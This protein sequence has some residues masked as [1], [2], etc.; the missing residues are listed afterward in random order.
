MM[1]RQFTKEELPEVDRKTEFYPLSYPQKS[2]W[3]MEKMYPSTSFGNISATLKFETNLD[4]D[5]ANN[6]FNHVLSMND[7]LRLR[8]TEIEGEAHQYISRHEYKKFDYFDFTDKG[9]SELYKWDTEMNRTPIYDLDAP[10]FYFAVI[11]ISDNMAGFFAKLHHLI[12]DAWT[13]VTL[14]NELISCYFDIINGKMPSME[15][16]PSYIEYLE[17]EKTYFESER[18]LKDEGFWLEKFQKIPELTTL[19][20]RKLIG[21]SLDS[22]RKTFVLPEKLSKKIRL[23]CTEHKTSIFSLYMGAMA[24]YINRTRGTS[25]IVFGTPVLNRTNFREKET[26]GMFISTVPLLVNVDE[27]QNYT[28][29]TK[30][31]N[32]E[33]MSILRHQKYPYMLLLKKLRKKMPGLE[34]LY[35]IIISYQNAKFIK[36]GSEHY[37]EGRW[38]QNSSQTETLYIHINDREDDGDIII[39]YDYLAELFYPK[40]IEFLHDHVIRLM[41]HLIDNPQR[42]LPYIEMISEKEKKK[43]LYDFNDTGL[44]FQKDKPL[45]VLFEETAAIMPDKTA[46][47]FKDR[48][49]TFREL[50]ERTNQLAWSLVDMGISSGDIVGFMLNRS[51]ETIIAM[52]GILKSGAAYMPIDRNFPPDRVSYILNNSKARAV[53][54]EKGVFNV[55]GYGGSIIDIHDRE[56]S[57]KSRRDTCRRTGE[58]DAAYVIYTSGSTG[59]PKGVMLSHRS[60]SNFVAAMKK[61]VDLDPSKTF[62]SITSETF[63]IFVFETLLPLTQGLKVIMTDENE[64]RIPERIQEVMLKHKVDMIQ[65]TPTRMNYIIDKLTYH[66]AFGKL[67]DIVLG[68]EVFKETLLK[69]LRDLTKAKIYNGYGPSETTIYSTF[70]DVT[71]AEVINIGRPVS[72]TRIYIVDKYLNLMPIGTVGELCISGEGVMKGYIGDPGAGEKKLVEN[73]FESGNLMFRTGDLASW[74]AQG[75]IVYAGRNDDQVKVNGLRIEFGEIESQLLEHKA[76]KEAAVT[77]WE[78]TSKNPQICAYYISEDEIST[79]DIRDKLAEKLPSYM[80]PSHFTRLDVLPLTTSGKI[81]RKSLPEPF[82]D[83]VSERIYEAPGDSLERIL[84]EVYSII[85]KREDIGIND[86]F[87]ELGGDSLGV[88]EMISLLYKYD[89]SVDIRDVYKNPIIRDLKKHVTANKLHIIKSTGDRAIPMIEKESL[90]EQIQRNRIKPV[91]SAALTYIPEEGPAWRELFTEKPVMYKHMSLDP[92]NIGIIAL[93]IGIY[94]LYNDKRKAVDLC[95]EA[96]KMA[97]AAGARTVS[98]TGLIPSA[99]RTGEDVEEA[100]EKSGISVKV[101]TG[102]A[103][104]A[105][106]VI[107]SMVRILDE[108]GRNLT[109][110]AVCILGAGSIGEAVVKLMLSVLPMPASIILCDLPAKSRSLLGLRAEIRKKYGISGEIKLAYSNGTKLPPEVY[111]SSLIIGA[112]NVPDVLEIDEL[113]PG[114]IIIDDSGPHCFSPEKAALRILSKSDLLITEGGVL[115]IPGTIDNRL[116]FPKKIDD[117]IISRFST[118]FTSEKEITGCIL[119]GLL[120]ALYKD[121][122]PFTGKVGI[123]DCIRN[124]NELTD[125]GYRGARLQFEDLIVPQRIIKAFKH[126]YS[127]PKNGQ[128]ALG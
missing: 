78:D 60:M 114:T 120:S 95:V 29:F 75:E 109:D 67:K 121:I 58:E 57:K 39:D 12:A 128:L 48:E 15:N 55:S 1:N 82:F 51:F 70:K 97:E 17:G 30:T 122:R 56:I 63:D 88:I 112:T 27:T 11:K 13:L 8:I 35:D 47:V 5:A 43:I 26:M 36:S 21:T 80:I 61:L 49:M 71:A 111:D 89:L 32:K 96:I 31:I 113:A 93:P 18:F 81:D 116:Y 38:H 33:W 119:S 14:G 37:Q 103:T 52:L 7:S 127:K 94:Q 85:L 6:A 76:I 102:H 45:H 64:Q 68:G 99:T 98:L 50:N 79:K 126:K 10:L 73:P 86:H 83:A 4:P 90:L 104:T 117:S 19:K 101:T 74:Y 118:H 42:Q 28:S 72:N 62:I 115:E 59:R 125:M 22:A 46:L 107:L 66:P 110:E 23:H 20:D 53:I 69:K 44:D 54:T 65:T 91:D 87:F 124:Y 100:V 41:W 34:K 3:Y 24:V 123:E 25:E 84:K 40:E 77:V 9:I 92:G 108:S 106:T 16:K 2:I 105:A